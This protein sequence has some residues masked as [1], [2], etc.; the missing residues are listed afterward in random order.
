M[1]TIELYDTTLRDGTQMEGLTFSL[2]DKLKV[3]Q[4]LDELGIHYVE[5][6]Y[7]GSNPKDAEFFVQAKKL[8]LKQTT[9]VA[10]GSTRRADIRPEGDANLQALLAAETKAITIVGKASDLH[11]TEVLRTSLEENLAM[12]TDSIR[13]LKSRGRTVF[14]DAEHYFDGYKR[15]SAYTIA[16]LKAA[17]EGGV[18]RIIPCDTNGGSLPHEVA[19]AIRAALDAVNVPIGIHTH[20][21]CELA[22]ANTLA[23]IAEGATQVQGTIN[24]YGERCGNA[25][26]CSIIPTLKL[27]MGLNV[28]SEAQLGSLT[29]VSRYVHELANLNPNPHAPFVGGSAF[30]HKAG[31]HADAVMKHEDS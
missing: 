10:F 28:L 6:G 17:A 12:I 1:T 25:N 7:P 5:G 9:I 3:A 15:N 30:A 29:E 31:L 27:K 16:C 19:Q 4:K 26:L 18:D 8:P 24:G 14:L 2:E 22:V 23:A 21:D 11:V 20:N 13:Y